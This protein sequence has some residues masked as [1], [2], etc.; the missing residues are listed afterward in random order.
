MEEVYIPW[1]NEKFWEVAE[2]AGD[3]HR[4]LSEEEREMLKRTFSLEKT[5]SIQNDYVVQ[6]KN[7]FFQLKPEGVTRMYTKTKCVVQEAIDW[8]IQIIANEK[9]IP[10][11]E[12]D[13]KGR[14]IEQAIVR[15]KIYKE[16]LEVIRQKEERR[17]EERH[18]LSKQKQIQGRVA[19]LI[20]KTKVSRMS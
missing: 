4:E 1:H 13:A 12:I 3:K 19:R 11:N 18:E 5:R 14:K 10:Y 17:K 9:T 15:W 8:E 7:R 20:E 6:Y 2:I 16:K